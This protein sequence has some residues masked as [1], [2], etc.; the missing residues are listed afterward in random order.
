[1]NFSTGVWNTQQL[2]CWVVFYSCSMDVCAG[3]V[4]ISSIYSNKGLYWLPRREHTTET[5]YGRE[6]PEN[7][8]KKNAHRINE[9]VFELVVVFHSVLFFMINSS[10]SVCTSFTIYAR[11]S[12]NAN[13]NF[14][15]YAHTCV[16]VCV[17]L[18]SHKSNRCRLSSDGGTIHR[19]MAAPRRNMEKLSALQP[20]NHTPVSTLRLADT[21]V[22]WQ[23]RGFLSHMHAQ[24]PRW[25]ILMFYKLTGNRSAFDWLWNWVN[26]TG[27]PPSPPPPATIVNYA[28]AHVDSDSDMILCAR[29]II[30]GNSFTCTT[31]VNGNHPFGTLFT[32]NQQTHACM[33]LYRIH[34]IYGSN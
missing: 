29:R 2:V 18:C 5:K 34:I 3:D 7:S 30:R 23:K 15:I 20:Q 31:G 14:W 26:S 9:F 10:S 25:L 11:I 13:L 24:S 1:M 22:G 19:L 4:N 6:K 28:H 27:A 12:T 21:N 17:Y 32:N 8:R 33:Y 16:C